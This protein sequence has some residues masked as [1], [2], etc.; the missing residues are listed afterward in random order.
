MEKNLIPISSPG[1]KIYYVGPQRGETETTRTYLCFTDDKNW[2][3]LKVAVSP[4]DNS[5][6]EKE[7]FILKTLREESDK[8]EEEYLSKFPDKGPLNNHFF[9][10]EVVD[11][12]IVEDGGSRRVLVLSLMHIAKE[13][14]ELSP[15]SFVIERERDNLS[16]DSR[17]SAWILGKLLKMLVFTQDV[18]VLVGDLS[19]SNILINKEK[20]YVSIFD[21]GNALFNNSPISEDECIAEIS[22]VA[23]GVVEALDGNP[24][25]G[26]IPVDAELT[27]PRYAEYIKLLVEG[28]TGDAR[29]SHK[30]FYSIVHS[31]WKGFYP[32]TTKAKV[33]H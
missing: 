23:I 20:H 10:P 11:S 29:N 17:T 27:D 14:K 4:Q 21:W 3:F 22:E 12:F 33:T 32:Y 5:L 31:I 30:E 16:I 1:G 6:L 7:E 24:I 19:I 2:Y 9:F 18:G 8:L 25:T 28:K 15:L 26:E 13:S